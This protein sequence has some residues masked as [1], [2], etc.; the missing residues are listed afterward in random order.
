V[1]HSLSIQ[2]L[3]PPL[4]RYLHSQQLHST[5]F[6]ASAFLLATAKGD[7]V[8]SSY[9][10]NKDTC[11]AKD[12]TQT[13]TMVGTIGTGCL[14]QG[15]AWLKYSCNGNAT[16]YAVYNNKDC[17]GTPYNNTMGP[18]TCEARTNDFESST[19][20]AGTFKA[21]VPVASASR[22]SDDKCTTPL[23]LGY[24]SSLSTIYPLDKCSQVDA[25]TS[26]MYKCINGNPTLV[27]YK[28]LKCT[29]DANSATFTGGK[30]DSVGSGQ[31]MKWDSCV[32]SGAS[33]TSVTFLAFGL[34][35]LATFSSAM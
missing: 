10:F 35:V 29:G 34:L 1:H 24:Y 33:S 30:C 16:Q 7:Y 20:V 14:Q 18:A 31:Y 32:S 5:L 27:N 15:S 21:S 2:K 25:T 17:T 8:I 9:Y 13:Y 11:T 3:P 22:Y 28:G 23:T 4:P 19:C 6:I 12:A 26:Q